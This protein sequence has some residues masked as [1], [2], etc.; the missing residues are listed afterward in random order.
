VNIRVDAETQR[1]VCAVGPGTPS[2]KKEKKVQA[3]AKKRIQGPPSHTVW[4]GGP[5]GGK[6]DIRKANARK[7]CEKSD[8]RGELLKQKTTSG[9]DQPRGEKNV[10][11]ETNGGGEQK[12]VGG[13]EGN[14]TVANLGPQIITPGRRQNN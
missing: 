7:R 4:D 2:K 14:G 12:V 1:R 10:I 5:Q 8:L 11:D 9:S 3:N 6:G 13:R